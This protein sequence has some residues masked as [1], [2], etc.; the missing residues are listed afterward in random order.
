MTSP[1]AEAALREHAAAK[2]SFCLATGQPASEYD[3]MTE[4]EIEAFQVLVQQIREQS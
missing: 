4:Y 2:A 3:R 1:K